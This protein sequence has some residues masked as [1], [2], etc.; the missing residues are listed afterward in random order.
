MIYNPAPIFNVQNA[1]SGAFVKA[2]QEL[3]FDFLAQENK[4]WTYYVGNVFGH[5]AAATGI[6]GAAAILYVVGDTLDFYVLKTPEGSDVRLFLNG[7]QQTSIPTFAATEAWE[8][9]TGLVLENNRINEIRFE[10]GDPSEDNETG[11]SWMTLGPVEVQNGYALEAY[12]VAYNTITFR[13]Q[14]TETDGD[15]TKALP[16]NLP[17][18]FTLAQYQAWATAAAPIIDAA[19]DSKIVAIDMTVNLTIPGGL[20]ASPAN[21][22]IN[23]RGGL[24]SF[25]TSGPRNDS[26]WLPGIAREFMQGDSID[27]GATEIGAVV[28]LLTTATTAANIRPVT[29]QDY[30]WVELLG[31]KRSMRK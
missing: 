24:L 18:G 3:A 27:T 11:V 31:G 17:T 6:P 25:S 2:G 22:V 26:V 10:N 9:I 15:K 1:L 12:N 13:T 14:D 4:P 30:N 19:L 23:E 21:N 5:A 29:F 28:T 8:L 16:I 20:K 7:V